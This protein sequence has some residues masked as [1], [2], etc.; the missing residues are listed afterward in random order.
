MVDVE[1]TFIS[2]MLVLHR[3]VSEG[4]E[5]EEFRFLVDESRIT[6]T[7]LGLEYGVLFLI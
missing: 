7:L 1:F 2:T 6:L 4:K 5:G 3:D